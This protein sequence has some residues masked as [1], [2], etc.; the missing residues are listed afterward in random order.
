[1]KMNETKEEILE[2]LDKFE[3]GLTTKQVSKA[4]GVSKITALKYLAVL[5]A[6]EK[7]VIREIGKARLYYL[8]GNYAS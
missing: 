7:I 3:F 4:V 1:M 2:T 8:K 6:E 5:E